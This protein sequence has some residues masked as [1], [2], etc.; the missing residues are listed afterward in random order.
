MLVY[1]SY[2]GGASGDFGR[3]VATDGGSGTSMFV[4]GETLSSS[5]SGANEI[6][7]GGGQDAF[8]AKVT[9]HS[10][11]EVAVREYITLIGGGE[12]EVGRGIAVD[13]VGR[14]YLTGVTNSANFPTT[15][16]AFQ[17]ALSP[18]TFTPDTDAFV[19]VL[20]NLGTALNYSTYLGGGTQPPS[21]TPPAPFPHSPFDEGH[22]IAI[23]GDGNAVITGVTAA[24]DFPVTAGAFQNGYQG[25]MSPAGDAFVTK[26][27][28]SD[29]GTSGD[30]LYS[31][32][33]GGGADD[34]GRGVTV[35]TWTGHI[36]VT[37]W[38]GSGNFPKVNELAGMPFGGAA[39]V[40]QIDPS[41]TGSA[42]IVYSTILGGSAGR[43]VAHG[44]AWDG[45]SQ[46]VWVV[47]ETAASNFP[48]TFDAHQM[49]LG[50]IVDA[51]VARIGLGSGGGGGFDDDTDDDGF[52]DV[53]DNPQ[54]LQP[55]SGG[56]RP[57]PRRR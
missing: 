15:A 5:L 3:A 31:T 24:A 51:F 17:P 26:I 49:S 20:N 42:S 45:N 29:N 32:Y 39:F 53:V 19:A 4:V 28:V 46:S 8:V 18:A 48:T 7:P 27:D 56:Q 40:A 6:G 57:R 22:A 16:G 34:D 11:G 30:L 47:G 25:G 14:A 21:P 10:V 12:L 33:L 54:R 13:V 2:L 9:L 23:D 55:R 35:D 1:S 38:A 50:G 52:T 41:Q 37:G 36:Y 43:T 44:I